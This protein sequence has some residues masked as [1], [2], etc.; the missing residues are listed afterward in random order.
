MEDWMIDINKATAFEMQQKLGYSPNPACEKCNG[1]GR[2]HP[3]GFDGKPQYDKTKLCEARGCLRDS[4][5]AR[6]L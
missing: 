1:F 4:Y 2:V 5:E 3:L 6:R